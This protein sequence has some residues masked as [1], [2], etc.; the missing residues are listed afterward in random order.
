M[1]NSKFNYSLQY[2]NWHADTK[3]SYDTDLAYA[4]KFFSDHNIYPK[5]KTREYAKLGAAWADFYQC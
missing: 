2:C 5:K 4:R 3:Q 1:D